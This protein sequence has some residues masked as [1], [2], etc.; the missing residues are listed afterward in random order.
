MRLKYLFIVALLSSITAANAD[1]LSSKPNK[2]LHP[3]H[4]KK[5]PEYML[6]APSGFSPQQIKTAYGIDKIT[7]QG[8]GQIIAIVDAYDDPFAEYDLGIFSTQFNLPACTTAN[9]CFKKI[10]DQVLPRSDAGWSSEIV[11]DIE[12]AHAIAPLAKIYLVEAKSDNPDDLYKAIQLAVNNGANI[13]SLSWGAPEGPWVQIFNYDQYFK[14]PNVTFVTSSGDSGSG[15]LFPASSPYVISVGGTSLKVD[16]RTG[17]RISETAWAGSSGGVS[18]IEPATDQQK[19]YPLPNNPQ[20]KRGVPDVSFNADPNT[21][22]SVYNS[23]PNPQG[24]KGWLVIG[25][26]SAAAPQWAALLALANSMAKRNIP[27]ISRLYDIAK[28]NYKMS[29]ADIIIGQNGTCGYYCQAQV[30]YDYVTGLGSPHSK[31]IVNHLVNP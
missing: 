6:K 10:Y 22:Y 1:N 25:G 5:M 11:L 12:W 21:G 3:I 26:T 17:K 16:P 24:E 31:Y 20:Q 19:A 30:N 2:V 28:K 27:A 15:V 23:M 13:V 18:V 8:D 14:V 7:N 4:I 29:Y 9:G